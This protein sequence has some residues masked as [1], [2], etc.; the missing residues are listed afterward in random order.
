MNKTY[1]RILVATAFCTFANSALADFGHYQHHELDGQTLVVTTSIGVLRMTALNTSAFEVH[2]IEDGVKQLPSFALGSG[3]ANVKVRLDEQRNVV[4]FAV[5]GLTAVISKNPV[6]IAYRRD[7]QP[8]FAEEHGYFNYATIRGFRFSVDDKEKI[9]GGGQRVVGMDRRG[10][11]MPL[12]NKAHYG[13]STESNQMYYSLPAILSS[14]KYIIAF[15]NTA[16]GWLDIASTE[17]NVLQ[18]EAVAGRTAYIVAAGDSYPDLVAS[19]T[20]ATGRQPLPPR[21][22]FGNFA[23]R[24]GYHSEKETRDVVRRFQD[25]D[26]PLD[27]VILDIYWFGPDIQGHMGNLDWDREAFPTPEKMISDFRKDGIKTIA[28]TEPFILSTSKLWGDAVE[29]GA[30][31]RNAT[32]GPKT[33]N[34]YFGNTGLID[35]FNSKARDWFWQP[36]KMLFDQGTIATWGDL[37][38]PEVHPGDSL[39]FLSDAGIEATADE[40]HNAYGHRWAQMVYEKQIATYPDV[41]PVVMMRSGFIGTQRYGL[42]PWTGDVDRSWGGFKPQVELSLQMSLFGL[43]YTHSDL[44]GFAGGEAFDSELYTR[45]LQYGVFQPVYR[46]HAQEHIA[47]EPVFHDRKTKALARDAIRL[48]YRLLPYI[49]TLAWENTTTGMPLMRPMFFEDENTPALIDEIGSYLWGDAFLVAPVTDPGVKSVDVNLPAGKWF[50]FWDASAYDG[51]VVAKFPVTKAT[52]PVLV[53]AGSF[54]PMTDVVASTEQYS[55]ENLSVHYYA[56]ESAPTASYTMY[57]DDG[58]SRNSLDDGQYELLRFNA[59]HAGDTLDVRLQRAGDGYDGMPEK[60][61]VTLIVHNWDAAT[62]AITINGWELLIAKKLPTSG[63]GAAVDRN[64]RT[65]TIRFS[66]H[67]PRVTVKVNPAPKASRAGKPVVYQ[68]FTR[69][70]GNQNTT[71]KSWGTIEENGVGKFSDF[72]DT[73]LQGI[74]E[75]GV[76]HIWYT[77]VPHHAVIRD[78]KAYGISDDDPDIVKGRAG[79]PYAVK[80]YYSVNPDLADDPSKRLAEF[81]AL[82]DRTHRNDMKVI[83]DIVPNHVARQYESTARPDGVKNFGEDDDTSV[84]W[85]RDN[86]FYYVV[87]EDFKVPQS[88]EPYAPLGGEAHLLAD[89]QFGESPAKW[90]GNG[91]RAPQPAFDDWFETVKVNYGVRPDG[92]YAFDRLPAD[93]ST[94]TTEQHAAFW[95]DKDVP[96]S[97]D[98][99][100]DIALYW[101]DKGVDGFRYD[102]AEMVPVEF[103]S[104]MNSSI[105]TANPDAFLLAEVYNPALYR[106]YIHLGRMDYLYDKVG[107][108]DTLRS[109]IEG[110]NDTDAIAPVHAEVLDIE[111]HML[112]FLENH[113]EQRI[114]SSD[115]A[116]DANRA[117]PAMVVSA[118]IGRSPTMLYFGQDVGEPGNGDPGFGA[119]TRT[120]IFDYWGV[121]GHQRWMNGGKFDG[122]QLSPGEKKLRDFSTRL[123][124]FSAE[125][126]AVLGN[127]TEIHSVNRANSSEY[128][129]QLFSFVRWNKDE[130]LIV[131]SNFS[132]T[133]SYDLSLHV[134]ADIIAAWQLDNGRYALHEKLYEQNHSELVVDGDKSSFR[135]RL[136]PLDSVVYKVG[137]GL[138]GPSLDVST[139]MSDWQNSGVN[140]SLVYWPD[141][142]SQFLSDDRHVEIWLPPGYNDD[143]ERRYRVIYMHDGQNLFDPRIAS[144]GVDWGVDEAMMRGVNDGLFE[145]AIV[146]GSWSSSRRAQEYSPWHD[147]PQYARFLIDELMP[148][149][150]AEFRTQTGPENTFAMG[151]SM[152]G[153]LS[154]YLVKNHPDIF[155]ACGCVSTHFASS[156]SN[157]SSQPDA[158]DS[159]PFIVKDIAAGES[160]RA[161][162][163]FF[164]DY[165]TETLDSTYEVD[166]M[167]VRQWLLDQGLTEGDDFQMREYAGA[168]HTEAA[169]R[170]RL[171]DQ[172]NWLLATDQEFVPQWAKSAIWYQ[173]FP[174]RFRN[175]DPSNDPQVSDLIGSDPVEPPKEWRVHP[176]GSDWYE[177]QDYEQANGEPELWKHFLRRR[178]GGDLQGIIDKLDYLKELGIN[179][180]YLNPVFDSPSLHKYDAASYH[181]IDPNFGPNPQADREMMAK[182]NPLD[183]ESWV[184]TEADKLALKLIKEAHRREIRIIFDGVFNHMGINSFAFKDLKE[185]QQRSP[186]KD[187]FTVKSFDDPSSGT[188]FDYEGWFGVKSLPEFKEDEMGLVSGPRDYVFNATRRWMNPNGEGVANGIDG[189]R[190]DV[191]YNVHHNFWKA[192]RKEVKSINP[193]AYLTAEIVAPPDEVKPYFQGDEFDGEMN[194]NFAFAAAEFFFHT[195]ENKIEASEFDQKLGELRD[196][197]PKG[198]AYVTQNLFG[199]HDSNRIGS[200]IVN[201]NIGNFRDWGNYFGLSQASNTPGYDVSKPKADDIALQKLFAIFQM[202]YVG[203]PMIYY[204]DE[205]GM[206]GANDPDCRKPMLWPDIVYD[207]EV[208]LPN[209]ESRPPDEVSINEDLQTH[210]QSLIKIRNDNSAL[211]TGRFEP[212]LIDDNRELY[213]FVRKDSTQAITVILNN[214]ERNQEVEVL[215]AGIEGTQTVIDL[216]AVRV[217]PIEDGSINVS[218]PAKSGVILTAQPPSESA[219][220]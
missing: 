125:S 38:E 216:L 193:E 183:P 199:S 145:P 71:N 46:P 64:A 47:P 131:V 186:Y 102:M 201:R 122:G 205:V 213:G 169:W 87:G 155:G 28:I 24:F 53:R 37:G 6:T 134:P 3:K 79:S 58:H 59:K 220:N 149:V 115:F 107:L 217:Y 74:A 129:G 158:G 218:I 54:I 120:S 159:T 175:G 128:D 26:I 112:H 202:T 138:F 191:A 65:L 124:T 203:A 136:E 27:T 29:N 45:W 99:F 192:W 157:F 35:V 12:Y 142:E 17:K 162:G 77:G 84:E 15:D 44:G 39:H 72:T 75:L 30:L 152:G 109:I 42:V 182:E 144:T 137:K 8:L 209:G 78:Y 100:R 113:D 197:Y 194:Y 116:A 83:I 111:E 52:I 1:R 141:V 176:W 215:I 23:S 150:N 32:G 22:A 34:F 86:N 174:E 212:V 51:G 70:F 106:D 33:F 104:Y 196:T 80:D 181:H 126:P 10:Q 20:D 119:A 207:D 185:N 98:K 57:E 177:L 88:P 95:A 14:D 62:R 93:A 11:R 172:L 85:S 167:P 110:N 16:N 21:W 206:W 170:A 179:A 208:F 114:A 90:T 160:V 31:A 50:S 73:A 198:V 76:S 55:S 178:Y 171:G 214:S 105:K 81:E 5:D 4:E 153:L 40:I 67:Q 96:D 184:W 166:H 173:I 195:D 2:Y 18:F 168:A 140:G 121:P 210:Y 63:A 188:T 200:H 41:R 190:L 66:W 189:W 92:S 147:A 151:S 148:R 154:F 180:I 211:R 101:T 68:V 19:F 61:Q 48:R 165:G 130:R 164:F 132:D 36:Y 94:W 25:A 56:D 49:Y 146:V 135:V 91:A 89:G 117:K 127:Y 163:R 118:L 103:W 156:E 43:A 219:P 108:Y 204:G 7:D 82:I 13:Y 97:W 161:G 143:P 187:W 60:R 133:K 9:L 123:M 69:L 139:Y